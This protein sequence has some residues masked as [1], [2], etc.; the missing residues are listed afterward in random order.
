MTKCV[1]CSPYYAES[2][3]IESPHPLCAEHVLEDVKP[4]VRPK[5]AALLQH[6][7]DE[8]KDLRRSLDHHIENGWHDR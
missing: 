4:D 8:C 1:R 3:I 5:V 7:F 6:L 2:A